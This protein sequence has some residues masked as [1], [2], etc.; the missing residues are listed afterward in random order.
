MSDLQDLRGVRSVRGAGEVALPKRDYIGG[1][2]K[3]QPEPCAK[4]EIEL[5]LM[6]MGYALATVLAML[7]GIYIALK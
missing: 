1:Q 7:P 6:H 3:P 5:T 4:C 2:P